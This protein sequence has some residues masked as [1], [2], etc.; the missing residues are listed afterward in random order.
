MDQNLLEQK[1]KQMKWVNGDLNTFKLSTGSVRV[2][3]RFTQISP[4]QLRVEISGEVNIVKMVVQE[5]NFELKQLDCTLS[6]TDYRKWEECGCMQKVSDKF[7]RLVSIF[8]DKATLTVHLHGHMDD[9]KRAENC[10]HQSI[11][12]LQKCSVVLGTFEH[13]FLLGCLQSEDYGLVQQTIQ[14]YFEK[15]GILASLQAVG[16]TCY[17]YYPPGCE[18]GSDLV[19]ELLS[20]KHEPLP[21]Q[22][23]DVVITDL[24]KSF[25]DSLTQKQYR[26]YV[27]PGT[28]NSLIIAGLREKIEESKTSALNFLEKNIKV[29]NTV[30]CSYRAAS[31]LKILDKEAAK[32]LSHVNWDLTHSNEGGVTVSG[33]KYDVT[34]AEAWIHN[35]VSSY[36]QPQ[37]WQVRN[38]GFPDFFRAPE[39]AHLIKQVQDQTNCLVLMDHDGIA[40]QAQYAMAAAQGTSSSTKM[41][42]SGTN[43][44][45][46]SIKA[47]LTQHQ[48]DVI[49]VPISR[50]LSLST[51]GV[52]GAIAKK[53]GK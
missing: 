38:R 3:L 39:N 30:P 26:Y 50:N 37:G 13:Q 45:I 15:C 18:S 46:S 12:E 36:I 17:L 7:Q 11:K 9:V 34:K 5:L 4:S 35:R 51:Q 53:G 2:F 25:T 24:W 42:I 16:N 41:V 44:T 20:S 1:Q 14:D 28:S 47:D 33:T 21:Q 40:I 8:C 32:E 19:K 27:K 43:V 23:Y 49:V 52:A 31:F 29:C 22:F 6:L 10:I 48:C